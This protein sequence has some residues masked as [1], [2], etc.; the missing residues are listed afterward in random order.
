MLARGKVAQVLRLLAWLGL[1]IAS[2]ALA[3][4]EIVVGVSLSATGPASSLGNQMRNAL[5]LVEERLKSRFPDYRLTFVVLDDRTD[6]T[7]NVQNVEK[8]IVQHKAAVLMM[9]TTAPATLAALPLLERYGVASFALAPVV[10]DRTPERFKWLFQLQRTVPMMAE[11]IGRDI[12]DRGLKRIAYIGF[13]DAWGDDWYNAITAASGKYGFSVVTNERYARTDTSVSG[14]VL[15]LIAARTDG[16]VVGASG[17]PA[18]LPHRSLVERGLRVPIY[19][20]TGT[21]LPDFIRVGGSAVEGAILASE[22]VVVADELPST[23]P[24]K[25]QSLTYV[26]A[27]EARYGRGTAASFGAYV[28]DYGY[29]L[30]RAL[31]TVLRQGIDPEDLVHFR[32][33]LRDAIENVRNLNGALGVI[34]FAPNKHVG[35]DAKDGV[36]ITVKGGRFRLYKTFR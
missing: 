19:H 21:T 4:K 26:T 10:D 15:R 33:A 18:A 9:S 7:V 5:A 35:T 12:Q 27:Y 20:T 1:V 29:V 25:T 3:Q 22:P 13:S 8:L 28:W 30:E 2:M 32:T 6:P 36:L 34:S 17:T 23:F 14:Q 11:L 16:D 24:F 31:S